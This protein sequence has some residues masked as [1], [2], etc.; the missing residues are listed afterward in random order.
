M[1]RI[2]DIWFQN[3]WRVRRLK[4]RAYLGLQYARG[5][6]TSDQAHALRY[7]CQQISGC[8]PLETIDAESTLE[9]FRDCYGDHPELPRLVRD[10]CARVGDKW[11]SS[12]HVTDAAQDWAFDLVHE[13]AAAEGIMLP[14]GETEEV[15]A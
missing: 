5:R 10:A 12:G 13:Y 9:A 14:A 11:S 8:Y 2:R 6:L 7:E 15:A 3:V 4:H 1:K